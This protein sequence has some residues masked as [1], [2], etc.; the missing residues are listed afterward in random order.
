MKKLLLPFFAIVLVIGISTGC[1]SNRARPQSA[2]TT[3]SNAINENA[4]V[5]FQTA[6][7]EFTNL[8]SEGDFS[9]KEIQDFNQQRGQATLKSAT[10]LVEAANLMEALVLDV[11]AAR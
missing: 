8:I 11:K 4:S 3:S 5:R 1:T 6:N 2:N 7:L 10:D 9:S